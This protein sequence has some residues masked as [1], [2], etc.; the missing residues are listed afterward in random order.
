MEGSIPIR[1]A[2]KQH[3][4]VVNSSGTGLALKAMG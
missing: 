2:Q 3:K 1:L 4:W